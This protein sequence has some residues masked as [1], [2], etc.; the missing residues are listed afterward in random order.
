MKN[1]IVKTNKNFKDITGKER[2]TREIRN[3]LI[4]IN[5]RVIDTDKRTV[6]KKAFKDMI[7]NKEIS[8]E[9]LLNTDIQVYLYTL[10]F[11]HNETIKIK[12]LFNIK[13]L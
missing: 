12:E 10:W 9:D 8:L 11:Y 7:L 1:I 4:R 6:I 2:E 3:F 5:N 13:E